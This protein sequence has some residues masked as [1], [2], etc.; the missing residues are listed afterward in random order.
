[1]YIFAYIFREAKVAMNYCLLYNIDTY[2]PFDY[3]STVLVFVA[4][5]SQL[6]EKHHS[7][8]VVENL[9]A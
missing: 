1:M 9:A 7:S 6:Q 8:F 2:A 4:P 5:D 3:A